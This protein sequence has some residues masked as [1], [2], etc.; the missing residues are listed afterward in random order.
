MQV[1]QASTGHRRRHRR[2]RRG[3]RKSGPAARRSQISALRLAASRSTCTITDAS[4][5]SF[6]WAPPTPSSTEARSA[7]KRSC[8][9]EISDLR[10][11]ARGFPLHLHHHRCKFGKLR[12][13][14]ADAIVDGGEERGKAVLLLGN[15][16]SP[17]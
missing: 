3:A 9:S 2:R 12:L 6:D 1:R 11:E 7:E 13:G 8:C 17:R 4:S 10:A 14:T 16:R 5:A 15:L